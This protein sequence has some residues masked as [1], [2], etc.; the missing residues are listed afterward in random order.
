MHLMAAR[1]QGHRRTKLR[2]ALARQLRR[3]FG[4]V[5]PVA[6][7]SS[8]PQFLECCV[9]RTPFLCP[10]SWGT[11]GE[12]H[13]WVVSRCGECGSWS[14]ITITNVRAA[15]LDLRLDAQLGAMRRVAERLEAERM[16]IEAESFIAALHRDLIDAA[17]FA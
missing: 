6:A 16:A 17:D 8:D 3:F 12:E 1:Q 9:C 13:W 10:T 5:L 4:P 7:G 15:L 11:A 14:K 2:T